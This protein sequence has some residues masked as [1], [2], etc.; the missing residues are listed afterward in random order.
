MIRLSMGAVALGVALVAAP[1][2]AGASLL[3]N[4]GFEVRGAPATITGTFTPALWDTSKVASLNGAVTND[5]P[6]LAAP[7]GLA[8]GGANGNSVLRVIDSPPQSGEN[9][10]RPVFVQ[11][12]TVQL[13][14]FAYRF[15][16]EFGIRVQA[17]NGLIS[18]TAA[19]GLPTGQGALNFL[20]TYFAQYTSKAYV[21]IYAGA[22][23]GA[24]RLARIDVSPSTFSLGDFALGAPNEINTAFAFTT[25]K[26]FEGVFTLNATTEVTFRMTVLP[27][28][29]ALPTDIR[30]NFSTDPDVQTVLKSTLRSLVLYADNV[31]IERTLL[32]PQPVPAPGA[33]GVFAVALAGLVAVRR[34]KAA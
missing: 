2:L 32:E 18:P 4:P 20:E 28:E 13:P 6:L 23:T 11:Q 5:C 1:G 3:D 15:G 14:A 7:L 21:E 8:C 29:T 34:R 33:L 27:D 10:V 25:M 30:A 16:G 19:S 17:T 9:A 12:T 31:F 26:E 24:N 22:V